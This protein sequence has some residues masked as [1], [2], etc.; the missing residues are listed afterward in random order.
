[1]NRIPLMPSESSEHSQTA[2]AFI[3][4]GWI[5]ASRAPIRSGII[6]VLAGP[7]GMRTLAVTPVSARSDDMIRVL[8]SSAAFDGP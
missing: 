2:G 3:A 4:S 8:A 6:R 7:P 1:M 5:S